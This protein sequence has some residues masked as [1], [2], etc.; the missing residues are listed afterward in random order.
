MKNNIALTSFFITISILFNLISCTG[1]N[2]SAQDKEKL[3][4]LRAQQHRDVMKEGKLRNLYDLYC[5]ELRNV[6]KKNPEKDYLSH[7]SFQRDQALDDFKINYITESINIE[8]NLA[9]VISTRT[10]KIENYV[11]Q[12]KAYHYWGFINNNWC[13]LDYERTE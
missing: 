2:I 7:L 10:A 6:I 9:I 3:L 12:I 5:P 1:H 8:G 13:L 11:K 4:I